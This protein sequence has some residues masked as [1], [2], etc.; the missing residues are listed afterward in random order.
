MATRDKIHCKNSAKSM[1]YVI[2]CTL[3]NAY[4]H[5]ITFMLKIDNATKLMIKKKTKTN[6]TLLNVVVVGLFAC[7]TTNGFTCTLPLKT[8]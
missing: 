7:P 8:S 4:K 6:K 1:L 3:I 5:L 2:Y